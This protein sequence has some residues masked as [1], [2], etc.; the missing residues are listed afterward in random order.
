[1]LYLVCTGISTV[2]FGIMSLFRFFKFVNSSTDR[3]GHV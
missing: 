1:M 2:K 3:Y